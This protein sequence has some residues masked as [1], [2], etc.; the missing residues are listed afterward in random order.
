MANQHCCSNDL[1]ITN[2]KLSKLVIE[3]VVDTK[4]D[5]EANVEQK[6][7]EKKEEA[8]GEVK[9]VVEENVKVGESNLKELKNKIFEETVLDLSKNGTDNDVVKQLNEAGKQSMRELFFKFWFY[10]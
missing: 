10:C 8:E 5:I 1:D 3:S 9:Q 2:E 7:E 4:K 6:D